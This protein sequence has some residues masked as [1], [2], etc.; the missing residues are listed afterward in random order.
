MGINIDET[1]RLYQKL[2]KE[3]TG[4]L[5]HIHDNTTLDSKGLE[6]IL[7]QAI[8]SLLNGSI[9]AVQQQELNEAQIESI[10]KD[11]DYKGQQIA[12]MIANGEVERANKVTQTKL[13][14]KDIELKGIDKSIKEQEVIN[15][16]AEVELARSKVRTESK[17]QDLLSKQ[18]DKLQSEINLQGE[19]KQT[20]AI[21]RSA[22]TTELTYKEREVSVLEAN[23]LLEKDKIQ[24]MQD[25]LGL[26][27]NESAENVKI[28][29][30]KLSQETIITS[31]IG[32]KIQA[33][34]NSMTNE[35]SL[36]SAQATTVGKQGNVYD[37]DITLKNNQAS[38][39][40]KEEL[41]LDSDK[42]IKTAQSLLI[43]RQESAYDDQM[44]IEKA[45]ALKDM[46]FGFATTGNE[47][48]SN[49]ITSAL[50]SANS[51]G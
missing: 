45:K 4:S 14:E 27:E 23:Q 16:M 51:L 43:S 7:A 44:K 20:E 18:I 50:S 46:V 38:K 19:Q 13:F 30:Q 34:I 47:V 26:K 6:S 22:I 11:I 32:S 29:K 5:T 40:S 25:E 41:L 37:A 42:S 24:I 2:L 28:L 33:E 39:V 8:P 15:K 31:K 48:P 36:K 12:E 21:R 1:T 49:L 17:N 10:K 3:T 9:Q 35:A